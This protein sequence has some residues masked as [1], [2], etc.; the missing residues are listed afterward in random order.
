MTTDSRKER[1]DFSSRLQKA[2]GSRG[3]SSD[4]PTQLMRE[5]N[6]RS[7]V[8]DSCVSVHA[9]RKWLVGE[10]IPTQE[11]LRILAEMLNITPEWL[12]F[13][14]GKEIAHSPGDGRLPAEDIR[15]LA[16]LKSL[17]D[18][19]QTIARNFVK[20]LTNTNRKAA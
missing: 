5:F 15:L 14:T 3:Y 10:A 8:I 6:A 13:G 11:K 4:S 16:D 17:D 9:V 20:M 18:K 12:R 7:Q 1:M 19:G 2:L